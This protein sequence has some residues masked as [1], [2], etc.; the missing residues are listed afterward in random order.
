MAGIITKKLQVDIAQQ[1]IDNVKNDE[2]NYYV[3][4]A[5]STA[6][7]DD[8]NPPAANQAISNY[9][10]NVYNNILY[11]KEVTNNDI[12]LMVPRYNWTN[13]TSYPA[14]N[15][16]D[17]DMFDKQFFVYN[18]SNRGVYK[19]LESGSGN[20]VVLPSIVSTS[21]FKT[22]DGYVWKYMYTAGTTELSKFGSNNYLP[23]TSNSSVTSAAIPGTI[24]T[25]KVDNGGTGWAAY[26]IGTLQNVVNSSV[27]TI[28]SNSSTN[29]NFYSNSAIYL[30]SGLGSSQYR[31]I[32]S[33][34]GPSRRAVL[35]DA[36]DLK[37]N[38]VLTSI[39]GTFSVNDTVTQNLVAL[40]ITSQSGYLQPGDTITQSNSGATATIITS[41]S[42]LLRV[43]PLTE[44]AFVL[45]KA[46][47]AG[48]GTTLGNST[49][50]VNTTSNTVVAAANARFTTVYAVG[51]YIKVGSFFHRVT[52]VANNTRLTIAGPFD[53][54]YTANAHYKINSGATVSSCTNIS[55]QGVIEFADVNSSIIS[56]DSSTG[57]FDLGEIVTQSSS[58]T[59][60]VVSFANSTKLIITGVTGSGFVTS[61]NIVG[62]TTNTY[63]NVTAIAANPTITLSNTSGS[64]LFGVPLTSSSGGNS[65]M[66][67][68]SIIPNEQTEYIISPKVT[69]TGDG[70]NAAAYSLV[71]TTTTAIS[72]IVVFDK[73]TGYT[74]ANVSVSANP[75][76]G[77]GAVLTPS[78]S[79]V[80][81]HGSNVAFELGGNY[82]GIAVTFS[83]TSIEQYNLPGS[84][85]FRTAG[86]IKNPLYDN[87][88]L[89]I[90]SYDRTKL[91]LSG[92]NTFTV[93]EV[94]YQANIATGIVV[95]SNTSLVE[96]QGVKGTFDKT[97]VNTTVIGL[98][99]ENTSTITNTSINEFTVVANSVVYQQ[100]SGAFGRLISSNNTTLR[101][102]NVEGVF[103][104][105]FVVYDPVSNAYANVTAVKTANNTKTLTF[106]YFN[107]I[108]RV[109]LSQKTGNF[110][111]GESLQ[112][113]TPI[114]TVIGTG[115]IYNANNDTDLLISGNTIAFTTNEKI[116]QGSSA[117]GILLSAN[118]THMKL[119][120]VRGT[121]LNGANVVGVTSGANAA[122]GTVLS[123]ISVADVDGTL[124]ESSDN[125]IKGLTSNA[126]GYA[127]YANSIIRPNL[128]RDT[129]SVLY[130]E[131]I[132]PA[133]RTDTSTEAVNLIIKF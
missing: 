115:L 10:H 18:E 133:T 78:I 60:G 107:Q 32:I 8:N 112:F 27:I 67:S 64:F 69:I 3:F 80:A 82:T 91:T 22:S 77:N 84:G 49:V 76:Y 71:N 43:K 52:A 58:S 65:T 104:S 79:P 46:I 109:T 119:T 13:N 15:K 34:D 113:I 19:V 72:S 116:T 97:A 118:S 38:I 110:T 66:T 85:S 56:Y 47:D 117:N 35:D 74:E 132:S 108:A 23:I 20:S 7:P 39:T 48:R 105:G 102:S 87:V 9:D 45:D 86:I 61:A 90:S 128:V 28:S 121:F 68:V 124:T 55:A 51:D 26:N 120:D 29:T 50:T 94:V 2:N 75:N 16:D 6:W 70:V 95:F 111:V 63:A 4:T 98:S 33:Y 81:G 41:N 103:S 73:G 88:Y 44:D 83:N 99:S 12:I 57:S 17:S 21:S 42:S 125:I 93:G 96:L 127:E 1:F 62:V 126:Q 114:G 54:A 14:Y 24:D 40:S 123:V 122:V 131:N 37:T 11:G 31:T 5:K 101:L 36:L 129:G 100:N 30:K 89:T 53:A 130:T 59:N 106:G 25:I 92:A